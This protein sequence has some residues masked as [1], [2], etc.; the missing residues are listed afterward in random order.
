MLNG[1]LACVAMAMMLAAAAPACAGTLTT[2]EGKTYQG[3][4]S[5][6]SSNSLQITISNGGHALVPI[7]NV[8]S[9]VLVPERRPLWRGVILP[10]GEQIAANTITRVDG[11]GV[12][13]VRPGGIP[14]VF[15][16][17]AVAAVVF[18]PLSAELWNHIPPNHAGAV[19][20]NGDFY[21]GDP[22]G[23][24]GNQL[25]ISSVLFGFKSFDVSR[26][27]KAA[28][29][30]ASATPDANE[31]VRLVDGSILLGRSATATEGRLTVDD[32]VLGSI[33]VEARLV[34]QIS[35]GG[36]RLDQLSKLVPDQVDGPSAG[37]AT[38]ATTAGIPMALL[39]SD[40]SHGLDQRPD[41]VLSWNLAGKYK[42]II[43]RAGVPLGIVPL[44]HVQFVV[45]VDG[46]ERFRSA[47]RSS[48][49]DPADIAVDLSGAKRLTLRVDATDP[50]GPGAEGLWAD[51]ILVRD[52]AT[53]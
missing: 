52:Q 38:D 34:A 4:I 36:D 30:Q 11:N 35:M 49:D 42:S 31:I 51:P 1:T 2:L 5:F 8:L 22:A 13:I 27:A 10:T 15:P 43:A 44:E 41:A 21:E 39:G 28:V 53:H 24:Y 6:A 45:L 18:R 3:F 50:H 25:K 20:D 14:M 47:P 46:G 37:Y 32:P 33:T 9:A 12:R 29:L 19:L 17:N 16:S 40:P 26:D 23:F 48:V 7:S